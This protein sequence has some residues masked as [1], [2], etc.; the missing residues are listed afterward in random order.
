MV[1]FSHLHIGGTE[2][3]GVPILPDCIGDRARVCK[4]QAQISQCG[5]CMEKVRYQGAY[6]KY[7]RRPRGS[8]G[9]S[10]MHANSCK[11]EGGL[12]LE[13][14]RKAMSLKSLVSHKNQEMNPRKCRISKSFH[15]IMY[16][17]QIFSSQVII[18]FLICTILLCVIFCCA[19]SKSPSLITGGG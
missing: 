8:G 11:G 7:A 5:V 18:K 14:A 19:N 16:L 15:G 6:I 2:F 10:K 17:S 12:G 4:E 9:V 3:R 13:Y 1:P